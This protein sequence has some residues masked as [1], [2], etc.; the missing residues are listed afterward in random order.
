[1]FGI[2]LAFKRFRYDLGIFG[3]PWVGFDNFRFFLLS[4]DF[5][6]VTRNTLFMNTLF[7]I[8]GTVAALVLALL[9]YELRNRRM[10]KFYQTVFITPHFLSWVLV[11]YLAYAFLE[12]RLGLMNA[13]LAYFGIDGPNW[14]SRSAA[15]YWPVILTIAS[16]WKSVG[17]DCIVYYAALVGLDTDLVEAARID[18][19]NRRQI[20]WRIL[21]PN[22]MIVISIMTIL[23]IGGIFRADFGLFYQVTMN[24][25]GLFAV[26]DVVDTYIFRTMMARGAGDFGVAAAMGLMQSVVGLALVLITNYVASKIDSDLGLF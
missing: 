22:I 10:L 19:A 24:S 11:A 4:N 9:L 20:M 18:G 12:P 17:L 26:T 25:P 21:L 23:K 13:M 3:S 7:I 6:Q 8:T 1:M 16:T 2:V 5:Y 15:G 14:Y